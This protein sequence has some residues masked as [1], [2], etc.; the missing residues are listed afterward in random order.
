MANQ[1]SALQKQYYAKEVQRQLY[2]K[3][4]ALSLA[5]MVD[6]PHGTTYHKP[7]IEFNTVQE[8]VK[9]TDIAVEDIATT[10]ETLVINRTPLVAT[11][12]DEVELLEIDYSLLDTV[13]ANAAQVIR[14]DLDGNFFAEVL[15]ASNTNTPVK[16][17]TGASGNTVNVF[18]QAVASLVN[19][20][21]DD[22][23]LV[24]V[25]DPFS[26]ALIGESALGRTFAESDLM[27]RRGF[28][29]NFVGTAMMSSS[30]L[31][32]T[33]DLAFGTLPTANDTVT[34]NGVVFTFV[35]T[36]GTTP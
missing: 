21:V 12:I 1:L 19:Q 25:S 24:S 27:F 2:Y 7:L 31:T 3:V 35:S 18:A 11:G 13:A 8:Y 32:T 26:M 14:E 34:V 30:L 9:N 17:T 15:N 6:M 23:N 28:R 4:S 10:D 5:K 36:I 29:G 20:G 33:A 16:L 22:S